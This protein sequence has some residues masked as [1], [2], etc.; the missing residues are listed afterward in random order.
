MTNHVW[1]VGPYRVV[2]ERVDFEV[3]CHRRLR[4]PYTGL[5]NLLRL[6][7]PK[8]YA[9][10]PELV[11]KHVIEIL[12]V[13]P[14]LEGSIDAAPA[15]LT[16]LAVPSERTRIY[17]ANRTRRLA[18]GVVEF[19]E[20]YAV[21]AGIRQLTLS[22]VHVDEADHTDQEFLAIMLRR[23]RTDRVKVLIGMRNEKVPGEL[24][25]ALYR[26]ARQVVEDSSSVS[27]DQRSQEQL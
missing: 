11:R 15:T 7:V 26:Y 19:L 14:E 4:G 8:V 1:R 9:R 6:L 27:D 20:S 5:G 24:A 21:L 3:D 2:R 10:W 17:P 12:S 25:S 23:I 13:A 18:H 22:F 16:A